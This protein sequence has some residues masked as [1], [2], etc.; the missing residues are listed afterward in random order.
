MSF[1]ISYVK[2]KFNDDV[3]KKTVNPI[4][5]RKSLRTEPAASAYA[6]AY[7]VAYAAAV[8]AASAA[9]LVVAAAFGLGLASVPLA[10][11]AAAVGSALEGHFL[12]LGTRR[13]MA[14]ERRGAGSSLVSME[15][16]Y[17][18]TIY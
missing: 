9:S 10:V 1:L 4:L 7:A 3:R 16:P 15:T 14:R 18:K 11:S 6:V 5:F 8:A 2:M 12:G 13:R 17:Y